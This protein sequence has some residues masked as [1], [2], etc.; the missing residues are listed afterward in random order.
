MRLVS[1]S[2]RSSVEAW[3]LDSDA[4]RAS[5]KDFASRLIDRGIVLLLGVDLTALAGV[6]AMIWA[7][8]LGGM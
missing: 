8:L 3:S 2:E 4:L 6:L 5:P 1:S 7:N